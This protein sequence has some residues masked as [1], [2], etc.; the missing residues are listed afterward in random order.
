MIRESFESKHWPLEDELLPSRDY[1]ERLLDRVEKNDLKAELLSEVT[2]VKDD[3]EET[4][5]PV[6]DK[7]T[8]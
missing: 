7:T 6:W 2:S 3:A 8:P 1:V 5:R 4:L